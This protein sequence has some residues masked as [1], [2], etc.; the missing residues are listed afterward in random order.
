MYVVDTSI[1]LPFGNWIRLSTG[2]GGAAEV[3]RHVSKTLGA[4]HVIVL[5]LLYKV[6]NSLGGLVD[7]EEERRTAGWIALLLPPPLL[8]GSISKENK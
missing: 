3:G 8:V 4:R 6:I 1:Y 7:R 5:G 2:S